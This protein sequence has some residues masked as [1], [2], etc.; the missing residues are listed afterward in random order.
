MEWMI[1]LMLILIGLVLVLL[2]LLVFTGVNVAGVLGFGCIVAG[3][4]LG[5][6]FYGA[7]AGHFILGT[8]VLLCGGAVRYALRSSTWKRLS[9]DSSVEATVEGVDASVREGDNGVTQGRLAPM[10]NVR[11]GDALV[12]AESISG[13]I[14]T[15]QSVEVVKVLK[16]KIIVK[17]KSN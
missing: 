16:N 1:V 6:S 14:D 8:T 7:P 10:G 3:L 11:V 9:L 13:Y 2:E 12:E 4:W 17:S 15:D 5:Y